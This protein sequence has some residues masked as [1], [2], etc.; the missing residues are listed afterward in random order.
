MLSIFKNIFNTSE[1]MVVEKDATIIDVRSKNE[2]A[3][4]H[5]DGAI[6]IPLELLDM[7]ADTLRTHAQIV[8]Y[9]RSGN[10]SAHAKKM[11]SNNGIKNIIDGG[12]LDHVQELMKASGVH[13]DI[14]VKESLPQVAT[15]ISGLKD[16]NELKILI[17]T[18][19]S[20]Q[21]DYSYLM[22]RKLEEH[23]SV[24]IHFLHV[25]DVPDTVTM[26]D[27]GQIETCGEIDVNFIKDQKRIAESKLQQLKEQYGDHIS[28]HFELGKITDTILDF[29]ESHHFDLIVMGTKGSWGV[30]EKMS[31]SQAQMIARRS[32]IPLLSLMCDRSDLVINDVLFVHDFMDNDDTQMPLMHKFSK[33]FEATYHQLYIHDGTKSLDQ[34]VL[35]AN[36]DNYAAS[37]Q[38]GK[39]FNHIVLS[40]DIE[41]GVKEFLKKQDV[42]IVF[43]GTHGKG[44]F[45]HKSG[46]EV[47]IKHL[48]KPII[49]FHLNTN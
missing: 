11:L 8:V 48:F 1:D 43:I 31:T 29:A 26:S 34:N 24:D 47:L 49:S 9:C 14:I 38:I 10:R 19:F 23:L 40:N 44:G 15:Q 3:S 22:A 36:M 37:H 41:T 12:S 33:Y 16:E 18:D 21:A 30:R 39:Y 42:D 25:M 27:S 2:F 35:F 4:G 45:F 13:S 17:P 6:N 7:Q 28:V 46:A 5:L 32:G 20:V